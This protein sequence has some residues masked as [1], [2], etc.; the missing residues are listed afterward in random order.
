MASFSPG[1]C[2]P[3]RLVAVEYRIIPSGENRVTESKS[4]GSITIAWICVVSW[5]AR[6]SDAG[7]LRSDG[8]NASVRELSVIVWAWCT[9]WSSAE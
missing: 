6:S 8:V 9:I 3:I 7:A 2:V 1:S 4:L 5:L